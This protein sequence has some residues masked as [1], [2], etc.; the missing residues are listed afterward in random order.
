MLNVTHRI[1]EFLKTKNTPVS[2]LERL[3]GAANGTI[4]KAIRLHR[5]ISS[6]WLTKVSELYPTLNMNWVISGRGEM[7]LDHSDLAIGEEPYGYGISDNEKIRLE[8]ELL[9]AYRE[10][11]RLKK[12]L[13]ISIA[14]RNRL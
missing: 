11:S 1:S 8:K 6:E 9:E 2:E 4:A 13:D 5:S 12:S 10:I 14:E 7:L 3:I